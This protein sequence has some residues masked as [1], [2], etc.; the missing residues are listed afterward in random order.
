M[1]Y[2]YINYENEPL[3]AVKE[4]IYNLLF[5]DWM[6]FSS[7]NSDAEKVPRNQVIC[8]SMDELW[9]C[10]EAL[11]L[12]DI[13]Q[14]NNCSAWQQIIYLSKACF[15]LICLFKQPIHNVENVHWL[16]L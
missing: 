2:K 8:V 6:N 9:I 3:I 14:F 15:L 10:I 12:F 7:K 5:P 16:H 4:I 11:I 1:F 13:E